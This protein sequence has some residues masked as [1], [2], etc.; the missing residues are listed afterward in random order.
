MVDGMKFAIVLEHEDLVSRPFCRYRIV[1]NDLSSLR[2]VLLGNMEDSA[3]RD[4]LVTRLAGTEIADPGA[5][6]AGD[7][8]E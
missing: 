7:V 5:V 3:A 8:W 2:T 1:E 4:K 6:F